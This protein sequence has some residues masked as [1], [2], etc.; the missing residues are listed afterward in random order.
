MGMKQCRGSGIHF[1]LWL[2]V[3]EQKKY[4]RTTYLVDAPCGGRSWPWRYRCWCGRVRGR[5]WQESGA[6]RK[7][8]WRRRRGRKLP[9]VGH[10]TTLSDHNL[11]VT[12]K[13]TN[14]WSLPADYVITC[15]HTEMSFYRNICQNNHSCWLAKKT[16]QIHYSVSDPTNCKYCVKFANVQRAITIYYH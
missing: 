15:L 6:G 10:V 2:R 5:W 1:L 7:R 9:A 4:D 3:V 13:Q 11:A 14:L 12:N 8:R 16:T